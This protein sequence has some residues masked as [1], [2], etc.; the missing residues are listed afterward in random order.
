MLYGF[1]V[2]SIH[3]LCI[4]WS[5][6]H[7]ESPPLPSSFTPLDPQLA[8]STARPPPFL[9]AT[10]IPLSV[11]TS[12][13][14]SLCLV[15]S[16]VGFSWASS[17]L[18]PVFSRSDQALES[19]PLSEA[20]VPF[21]QRGL[22][23]DG[24]RGCFPCKH[25]TTKCPECSRQGLLSGLVGHSQDEVEWGG[26]VWVAARAVAGQGA[27]HRRCTFPLSSLPLASCRTW[28]EGSGAGRLRNP[29]LLIQ[30]D[31]KGNCLFSRPRCHVPLPLPLRALL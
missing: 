28:R 6:H 2:H 4:V 21:A 14:L 1:Q 26:A 8:P 17:L 13:S 10:A 22:L 16:G 27:A 12:L 15:P 3:R 9:L 7:P 20:V 24:A 25:H 29:L 18:P 30:V 31:R 11:S 5:V 23:V 19:L